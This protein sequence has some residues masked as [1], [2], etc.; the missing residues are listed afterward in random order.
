MCFQTDPRLTGIVG[1]EKCKNPALALM[2]W[3]SELV[4]SDDRTG[5]A[6]AAAAQIK[7]EPEPHFHPLFIV[8]VNTSSGKDIVWKCKRICFRWL[9]C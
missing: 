3:Y 4:G 5:D 1:V 6:A 8:K 7:I 9:L 2:T